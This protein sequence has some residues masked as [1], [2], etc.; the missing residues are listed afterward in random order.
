MRMSRSDFVVALL[1]AHLN[2][3]VE[4]AF[5]APAMLFCSP[6]LL[7]NGAGKPSIDDRLEG[8]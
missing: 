2:Q 6:F 1:V 8:R 7:F 4:G 5:L 3:P